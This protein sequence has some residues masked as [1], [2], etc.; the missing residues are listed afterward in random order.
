VNAKSWHTFQDLKKKL[1]VLTSVSTAQAHWQQGPRI[2]VF[3]CVFYYNFYSIFYFWA[4]RP[5]HHLKLFIIAARN[6]TSPV[7]R[8][9]DHASFALKEVDDI[10]CASSTDQ[11]R[12]NWKISSAARQSTCENADKNRVST[13]GWADLLLYDVCH[14]DFA[15]TESRRFVL[16]WIKVRKSFEIIEISR[17]IAPFVPSFIMTNIIGAL[18]TNGQGG[19]FNAGGPGGVGMLTDSSEFLQW[20]SQTIVPALFQDAVCGDGKCDADEQAALGRFGW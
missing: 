3:V 19:V 13:I 5:G 9:C 20:M 16:D 8:R 17:F 12:W 2:P 6:G 7:L 18:P 14:G 15:P 4:S 11:H 10:S 1:S